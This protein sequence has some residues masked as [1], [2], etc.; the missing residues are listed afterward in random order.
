M[1]AGGPI[2]LSEAWIGSRVIAHDLQGDDLADVLQQNGDAS[3]W[4]IA[5]REETAEL[6]RLAKILGLDDYAVDELLAPGH[7]CRV[8]D[9]AGTRLVR[10]LAVELKNRELFA[11]D[12]SMIIA[13]QVVI[14]LAD[15][16]Y[17]QRIARML[18]AAGPRLT[19][20]GADR[21]AQ[22]VVDFV[23]DT[24]VTTTEQL[25]AASDDLADQLFGG[26]P[27]TREGKLDAFRLRRAVTQLRRVT[28]PTQ[29]VVQELVDTAPGSDEVTD[30]HWNKIIDRTQRVALS[31]TALA[32]G[33]TTI[34]DTSLSLDNARL[35]DVMKKLTGWAAIIAAPTLITGFVG[36]NV[37]FWFQGSSVGF[38]V[39]LA[40]MLASAVVLYVLFKRKTWI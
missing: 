19:G 8:S 14:I 11:D 38:Y 21:A 37:D 4:A 3:A 24:T 5:P 22:L 17:G 7:R 27:L 1:A 2:A 23:I 26:Q 29:D 6:R 40:V 18:T 30:R 32:D 10:L 25:E 35:D 15:D 16:P 33:L 39:Y 31:V 13:D 9:V 34:F 12:V 36:M 28:A 20:G